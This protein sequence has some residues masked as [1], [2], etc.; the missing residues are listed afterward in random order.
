VLVPQLLEPYL[1]VIPCR[2]VSV[3]GINS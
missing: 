3:L 1:N 2:T